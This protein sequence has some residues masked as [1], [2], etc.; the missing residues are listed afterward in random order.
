MNIPLLGI[1]TEKLLEKIGA[2]NHKPGSGSAAALQAMISSKLLI[3]VINL[4]DDDEHRK[5]YLEVLPGLLKL[6]NE[7]RERIYPRL[8]ELFQNDSIQF[9]KTIKLR[10][11]RNKEENLIKK[12][13]LLKMHL[14]N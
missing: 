8:T 5:Y 4:T 12:N 10:K 6:D 3:T 1:T 9:D 13:Q 7:I 2:G 11:A 14:K